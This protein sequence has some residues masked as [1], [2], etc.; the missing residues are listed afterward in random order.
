[1][2]N[3]AMVKKIWLC[4]L[5][6]GAPGMSFAD[7]IEWLLAPYGWLPAITLEQSGG[8]GDP[9]DGGNG[10]LGGKSLLDLTESF[11]KFRAE[12]ARNRWGVMLDYITLSLSDQ[13]TLSADPPFNITI[14]VDARLDLEVVELG[15]FYR[16]S[17]EVSGINYLVGL[18]YI[19]SDTT[20]FL[21]PS[22]GPEQRRDSTAYLTD[23]YFGARYVHQFSNRWSATIR[24]DY[25]VGDSEGTLNLLGSVGF[26]VAGPFALQA[27]YRHAVLEFEESSAGETVT[28]KIELSGPYVGL[29]FRF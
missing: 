10:G 28:A 23:L 19:G 11:F 29:V 5:L 12:A 21:T 15:A 26:R 22:I 13:T 8:T 2:H 1:M 3:G 20:L 18:R 17:G 7:D 6:I 25:S 16:P 9:G 4:V 27:G 24:G 14:D